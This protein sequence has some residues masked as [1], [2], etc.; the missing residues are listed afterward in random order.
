MEIKTDRVSKAWDEYGGGGVCGR[1]HTEANDVYHIRVVQLAY[2][3]TNG[4]YRYYCSLCIEEIREMP[5]PDEF[6]RGMLFTLRPGCFSSNS[7]ELRFIK[8]SATENHMVVDARPRKESTDVKNNV[9]IPT[10]ILLDYPYRTFG[11]VK[12]FKKTSR[13][14]TIDD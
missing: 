6:V 7:Y 8:H 1:C 14:D 5:E 4:R 13:L 12:I 11:V 9:V 3:E 10:T 2:G